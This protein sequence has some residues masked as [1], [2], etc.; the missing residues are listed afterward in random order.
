[1]NILKL[2][3]I[4]DLLISTANTTNNPSP[5]RISTKL[6]GKIDH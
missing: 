6:F 1:M 2:E 5:E 4:I 3:T